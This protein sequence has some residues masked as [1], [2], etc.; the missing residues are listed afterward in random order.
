MDE[1]YQITYAADIVSIKEAHRRIGP[2]IHRTPVL[3]SG[4]LDSLSGKQLFFKCECFQKELE[5]QTISEEISYNF[6]IT[7]FIT[8]QH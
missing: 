4:S 2:Y 5:P 1:K 3:T 7:Q 6:T 8:P